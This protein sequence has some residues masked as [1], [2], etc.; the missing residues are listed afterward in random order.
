MTKRH[1]SIPQERSS[2][3]LILGRE[4]AAKLN[5]VEGVSLSREIRE[6]FAEFDRLGLPTE[7]RRRR[8]LEKF[9]QRTGSTCETDER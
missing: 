4:A 7:E 1:N 6:M 9:A 5:A 3:G 8:L 2:K